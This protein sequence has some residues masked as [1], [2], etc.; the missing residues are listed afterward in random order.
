MVWHFLC[1]GL[2]GHLNVTG[3]AVMTQERGCRDIE[4]KC[5]VKPIIQTQ[6][7]E[8]VHISDANIEP[9]HGKTNNLYLRKQRRRSASR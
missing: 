3:N 9:P 7:H 5:Q 1:S 8:M 6:F 2:F 4:R